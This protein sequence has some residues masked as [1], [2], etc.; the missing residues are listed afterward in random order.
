MCSSCGGAC[1][2]LIRFGGGGWYESCGGAYSLVAYLSYLT[3]NHASLVRR[4]WDVSYTY[5]AIGFTRH[6]Q[7]GGFCQ[8]YRRVAIEEALLIWWG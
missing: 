6:C 2:G 8:F 3:F 7:A 4:A 5:T 1:I